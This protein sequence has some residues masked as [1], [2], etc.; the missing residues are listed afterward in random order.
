MIDSKYKII[1][2]SSSPRRKE[3]LTKMGVKYSIKEPTNK[4]FIKHELKKTDIPLEIARQKAK[5][6][7]HHVDDNSILITAD[8]IVTCNEKILNK[9]RNEKEACKMLSLLSNRT[10]EVIT[11]VYITSIKKQISFSSSTKVTFSV[12]SEREINYYIK[13]SNPF[14]KAGGYGIQDWIG[15]IGIK[16]IEGSYSNVLG[17]PSSLLYNK[18]RSF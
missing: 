1:L 9:P 12:L 16:K 5:N 4:E 7:L 10:H 15:Y 13:K 18:L 17:L 11:G 8:T 2:G 3:I 6:L 14:D